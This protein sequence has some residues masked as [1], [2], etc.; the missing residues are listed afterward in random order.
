LVQSHVVISSEGDIKALEESII[1]NIKINS[2]VT[3]SAVCPIGA[4]LTDRDIL[5]INICDFL[6]T[7]L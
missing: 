5:D 2:R 7:T 6:Y 3:A 1:L 4:G